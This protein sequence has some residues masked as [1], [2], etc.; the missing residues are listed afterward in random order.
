MKQALLDTNF[1]LTCVKQKIDFFEE[2]YLNGIEPII[3]KEVI[4]EL[5]KLRKESALKLLEKS[6]FQ[7]ISLSG[8]NVDNAIVNFAKKNPEIIIATMDKD[9][10]RKIK[11]PKMGIRNKK[12]LEII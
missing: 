5:K 8:K 4:A 6:I 11:N 10:R 9:M 12:K 7:I 2:F 1:I 3:P